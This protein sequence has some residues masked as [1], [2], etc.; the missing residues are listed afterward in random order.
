[1]GFGVGAEQPVWLGEGAPSEEGMWMSAT[2]ENH[3]I[4]DGDLFSDDAQRYPKDYMAWKRCRY[5]C[6]DTLN[7]MEATAAS[8]WIRCCNWRGRLSF[9]AKGCDRQMQ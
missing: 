7:K 3:P 9:T 2:V 4:Y 1:V 8:P 5:G 6:F